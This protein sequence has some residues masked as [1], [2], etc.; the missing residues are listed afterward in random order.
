MFTKSKNFDWTL[1]VLLLIL[2]MMGVFAIYSASTTKIGD[3]Y[4][5]KNF[6]W[7]QA[8]FVIFVL[9]TLYFLFR[10]PF[11]VIDLLIVPA[12]IFSLLT[13][14]VVLFLP[15]INGSHRWFQFGFLHFQPS[16]MAKLC[17]ILMVAKIISKPYMGELSIML[18]GFLVTL[19][20]VA[21]IIIEPD[22][23]TTVVFCIS[24][25][26]MFAA[27]DIPFIYILLIVSPILS[28][29]TSF[30]LLYFIIFILL[31]IYLLIKY[32]LSWVGISIAVVINVF[33]SLI[34]PFIWQGLK[35]YQQNRILTFLD[36]TLDPLGA[37]YQI[38]QAKIAIG[39]GSILGKGFLLGTQK[40]MNFLPEHHTDFIFSVIGEE[41]GFVGSSIL[42]LVFFMFLW[43]LSL[44]VGKLNVRERKIATAGIMAYLS[45]QIFINIGMN[46]GVVPT[47]GI[48]LPF[49][50]YGGSN[51]LINS[52]AVGM[53]MKYLLERGFMK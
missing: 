25:L 14:V 5:V 47:T 48:P 6:W 39:S 3:T 40:N 4:N 12:Y 26:A 43:R 27:A 29:I 16:E 10:I 2:L 11:A 36:P 18:R 52:L 38:I 33:I 31:L 17:T 37:G 51:L 44:A 28:I 19:L 30:Y 15:T 21:L 1:F 35:T 50:S 49:I 9:L 8:I 7:K 42:L 20:P 32:R 46:I 24:L 22:F 45:F 34:T 41:F 13:L 53:V 23:G